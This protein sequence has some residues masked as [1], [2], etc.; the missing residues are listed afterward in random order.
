MRFEFEGLSC[1]EVK[2]MVQREFSESAIQ[3]Y[4]ADTDV[5]FLAT[6]GSGGAPL[7]MAMWF[8]HDIDRLVMVSVDGLAKVRNIERDP[9]V[10]VV[11]ESGGR[12]SIAV[13]AMAGEAEFMSGEER[14]KWG[15]RFRQKYDPHMEGIWGGPALPE[16]RRVFGLRPRILSALGI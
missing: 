4:L 7:G 2:P 5:V 13:L 11:A 6:V 14:L 12:G 15:E 8:V 1:P 9:M 3:D 16:D 10:S